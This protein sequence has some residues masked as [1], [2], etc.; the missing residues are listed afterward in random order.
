MARNPKRTGL[1]ADIN[2][3]RQ[4][5]DDMPSQRLLDQKEQ[6]LRTAI[7]SKSL[8]ELEEIQ[9]IIKDAETRIDEI[10]TI[11]LMPLGIPEKEIHALVYE[12]DAHEFY[13]SR[14]SAERADFTIEM[15][16]KYV[17]TQKDKMR[18]LS[19]GNQG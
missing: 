15:I 7:N 17:K 9:I 2:T 5:Y 6:L 14:F 1:F 18:K 19:T 10:N 3:L 12:R 4:F 16:K 11:L 13:L 8:G